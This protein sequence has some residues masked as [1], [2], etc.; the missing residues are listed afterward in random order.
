[1]PH[2]YRTAMVRPGRERLS[3]EVEIDETYV[4]GEVPGAHGRQTTK[5]IVAVAV[6]VCEPRGFGRTR[7]QR[8]PDLS[9]AALIPFV[10]DVVEPGARALTDGRQSYRAIVAHER[11]S[12]LDPDREGLVI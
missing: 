12:V 9:A 1:M 10:C 11:N 2:R 8:V 6:E 7:L 5:A 4:G 3:V